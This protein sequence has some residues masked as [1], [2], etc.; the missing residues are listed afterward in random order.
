MLKVINTASLAEANRE[1]NEKNKNS[2]LAYAFRGD[3]ESN[4]R[5]GR[6]LA[7]PIS[8]NEKVRDKV[9]NTDINTL[10]YN[11]RNE[12]I[13]NKEAKNTA[14]P[15]S[16]ADLDAFF[17]KYYIDIQ[18]SV[19]DAGDLT[20]VIANEVT[21]FDMPV[22]PNVR[23]YEKFRGQMQTVAGNNDPVPLIQQNTGNL[24]TFTLDIKAVGWK[25]SIYNTLYNKWFN[26]DKVVKA[27][28]D[29]YIDEK[30]A[31]TAGV[32][33]GTTYAA[34]Q[35]QSYTAVSGQTADENRY[36]ALLAGYQKLK[37]LKDIYTKRSIP[38][39]SV[40]ILCNSADTWA[41]EGIIRGQLNENGGGA[42]GSNRRALPINQ[43][44]EF[45]HGINDGFTI[46]KE[47]VSLP[48][49]TA[50]TVY[51]FVPGVLMI[52]N[53]RPLTMESGM[54]SV[55]E[56]STEERAWYS[57]F[58]GFYKQFLGTSFVGSTCGAGYGYIVEVKIA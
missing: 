17:G 1:K 13:A 21:D 42:R 48:G 49:C 34:S 26:M 50:G 31:A 39:P 46:G 15:P 11:A 57:V 2:I 54:G 7:V 20:S 58:G 16:T 19:A 5:G 35:K 18:R 3:K 23:D 45:D 12:M 10:A 33:I 47:L 28:A 41:L 8:L 25:D 22:N 38:V 56:L 44:I 24:D 27:A 53:K 29:A 14:T 40:S 37:G 52:G 9:L 6:D 36:D 51:M 55:L 43:I 32:I 30:N 4:F